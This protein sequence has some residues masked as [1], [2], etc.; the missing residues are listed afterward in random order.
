MSFNLKNAVCMCVATWFSMIAIASMAAKGRCEIDGYIYWYWTNN[1]GSA[2]I[3]M[4][5]DVDV[6]GGRVKAKAS[7][8]SPWH[9]G[10]LPIPRTLDGHIVCELHS[11][12]FINGFSDNKAIIE[13]ELPDSLTNLSVSCFSEL[14]AL[15]KVRMPKDYVCGIDVNDLIHSAN[16]NLFKF[17]AYDDERSMCAVEVYLGSDCYIMDLLGSI[18]V[19]SSMGKSNEDRL[20]WALARTSEYVGEHPDC[21][22]PEMKRVLE[23]FDLEMVGTLRAVL[24]WA[25]EDRLDLLL[26]MRISD[27][28]KERLTL[29][30]PSIK[31]RVC[32]KA[33]YNLIRLCEI[34]ARAYDHP[35]SCETLI[36]L[37]VRGNE[38]VKQVDYY[39]RMARHEWKY[40]QVF[41]KGSARYEESR[42]RMLESIQKILD[43]GFEQQAQMLQLELDRDVVPASK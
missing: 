29:L 39:K 25:K 41:K 37:T 13:I 19:N 17:F 43:L 21:Y 38:T 10:V 36:Q 4:C 8:T 2:T 34:F 9:K 24:E 42:L 3:S 26:G 35:R 6:K 27:S 16:T 7:A 11:M 1:D 31:D 23:N 32:L 18:G 15:E 5:S 40:M 30:W 22:T 28:E 12:A 20:N 33:R 14:P